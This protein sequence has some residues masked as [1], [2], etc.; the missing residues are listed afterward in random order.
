MEVLIDNKIPEQHKYDWW[1]K[2]FSVKTA[3]KIKKGNN[4]KYKNNPSGPY[5]PEIMDKVS[6][7]IGSENKVK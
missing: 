4:D 5:W 3:T 6:D 2:Q 7:I 1:G